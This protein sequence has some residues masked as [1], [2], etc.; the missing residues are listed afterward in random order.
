MGELEVRNTAA[1]ETA[2]F[3]FLLV[4]LLITPWMVFAG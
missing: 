4:L 2:I 1:S 3:W